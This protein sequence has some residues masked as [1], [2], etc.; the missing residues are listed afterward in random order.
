DS[1]PQN[2]RQDDHPYPPRRRLYRGR[3]SAAD[4]AAMPETPEDRQRR[5]LVDLIRRKGGTVSVRELSRSSRMFRRADDW[6][7]ALIELAE[8]GL[9]R[10]IHPPHSGRGR[11]GPRLFELTVDTLTSDTN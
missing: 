11:P 8:A 9:G 2:G 7:Q 3:D 6:E 10:W 1:G 5:K 4:A